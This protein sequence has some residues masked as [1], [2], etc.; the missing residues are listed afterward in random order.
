M[1]QYSARDSNSLRPTNALQL[2]IVVASLRSTGD[3]RRCL[4]TLT[5]QARGKSVEIIVADCCHD[6]SLEELK[7]IYP[8]VLFMS[9]VEATSLPVLLGA[10]IARSTGQ[11]IALTD[12][13]C[14]I[15]NEWVD[16]IL[17]AH[18]S[19]ALVIGGAVEAGEC[20]TLVDWAAYFCDYA[21]FMRP[22][23]EGAAHEVPGNNVSFKRGAL[24]RGR[25]FVK[26]GFWKTHWCRNLQRE[27]ERLVLTPSVVIHNGKSYSLLPFLRRRFNHGRCF[28][29]MRNAQI[30]FPRRVFYLAASPLLPLVFLV[31]IAKRVVPKNRYI[32]ELLFASPLILLATT[33]WSLGEFCG[34]LRGA[35]NSCSQV[36]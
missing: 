26:H 20:R 17:E 18:N 32:K 33:S 29:G 30:P 9:F 3:L 34:Y 12:S 2:S 21:Q 15:D 8:D 11:V 35:G 31:R 28:A 23:E 6:G 25:Q 13:T 36:N 7:A 27:G 24:E 4:A 5:T 16:S 1:N 14:V 22:F 19:P 10:S